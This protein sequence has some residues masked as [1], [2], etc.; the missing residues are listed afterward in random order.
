MHEGHERLV[1][2]EEEQEEEGERERE[3][4][5]QGSRLLL[6]DMRKMGFLFSTKVPAAPH[7]G[8][9]IRGREVPHFYY[10]ARQGRC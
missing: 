5:R 1:M 6:Q 7:V 2:G 9:W 3:R 10:A 8:K 4:G